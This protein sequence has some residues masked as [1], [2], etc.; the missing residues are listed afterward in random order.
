MAMS[1]T[2]VTDISAHRASLARRAPRYNIPTKR[3]VRPN[4][5]LTQWLQWLVN[6]AAVVGVLYVLAVQRT[7]SFDEHYRVLAVTSVLLMVIVYHTVG[8]FRRYSNQWSAMARVAQVWLITC[9]V[10]VLLGF[11]TKTSH[12]YSRQVVITW[13]SAALVAQCTI[14]LMF[15]MASRLWQMSLKV[16]LPTIVIGSGWLARHLIGS[17]NRNVF[18]ADQVVGVVDETQ[19]LKDWRYDGVP[20]LGT[21]DDLPHILN[22]RVIDRVYIALPLERS[23]DVSRLHETLLP[24]NVDLIW[25]PD[26]F[27]LNLLNPSVREVAGVPLIS[28]SESPLTDGG[29]AYLKALTDVAG[30]LGA[31][32]LLSP[33]M[34]L[35][36][37][38]IKLTSVGPALYRQTRTGWDGSR[39]EIWK[40]RTMYVHDE[41]PGTLTQAHKGDKRVTPVGRFLRRTSIDELPQLFNVLT[42]TM[43]LVGPRPHSIIHDHE[44][45]KHIDAYMARH[46][47]KP[48]MT[49]W[50]QIHGFRGQTRTVEEMRRRVEYDLDYINRWSLKLDLWIMLRTPFALFSRTAY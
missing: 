19:E 23:T 24:Y 26:I 13:F 37:L 15:H 7:G 8:V 31:L 41:G 44:Y 18:L 4:Q 11:A 3:L 22:S 28:L 29:R 38:A 45:S 14:H 21:L 9:A 16:N 1:S 35:T 32:L 2:K 43:S 40:F 49:G 12:H 34:V 47:I 17:I 36:V 6:A 39:F 20:A 30:A 48:G 50:A 5:P 42:G 25:V 27:S 33:I 10:I 46:R